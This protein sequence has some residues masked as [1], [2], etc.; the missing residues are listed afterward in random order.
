MASFVSTLLFL[1]LAVGG[2]TPAVNQPSEPMCFDWGE[3]SDQGVSVLE[4]EVGWLSC[5]LFSHPS[6]YNYTSTQSTG[7]NLF[8]YRLPEGHDL[9]QPLPYSS[10][11]S[12]DG[13]RLWLQPSAR[14][15]RTLHLH[16]E[17]Q[18]VV[19]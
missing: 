8:W 2:I 6:V 7:H 3:S 12:R 9:E 15:H 1:L 16:A 5:P 11:I 10:R 4:G 13:V 18:D 14:R 17:E 19:Q